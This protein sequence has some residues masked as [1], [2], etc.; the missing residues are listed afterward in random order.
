MTVLRRLLRVY[1]RLC[2]VPDA[3]G[4][5]PL[6]STRDTGF[7]RLLT[8]RPQA[9]LNHGAQSPPAEQPGPTCLSVENRGRAV[10]TVAVN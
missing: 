8:G 4:T 2:T 9:P 3:H 1:L 5:S 10:H 7:P 6:T